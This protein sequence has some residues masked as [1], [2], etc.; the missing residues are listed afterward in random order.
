MFRRG[1]LHAYTWRVIIALNVVDILLIILG[2]IFAN[3]LFCHTVL[4]V[5]VYRV[6][7]V[8]AVLASFVI[9]PKF[10]IMAWRG[11]VLSSQLMHLTF[12][13]ILIF[14]TATFVGFFAVIP[15]D[16]SR[17]WL[18]A[19]GISSWVLLI[20]FQLLIFFIQR[21]F[22][23]HGW[24]PKK[25]ILLGGGEHGKNVY[26]QL[27]KTSGTGF[28]VAYI[29]DDESHSLSTPTDP[30]LHPPIIQP[31][32][33]DLAAFIRDQSIE[34]IW[35]TMPLK[36]ENK[37][38]QILL[39]LRNETVNV[40][41]VPDAFELRLLHHEIFDMGNLFIIN[42]SISPMFG[43]NRIIKF[44]EDYFLAI[45]LTIL[46]SPLLFIIAMLVKLTSN[47]PILFKQLRHGWNGQLFKVYK[48]RTMYV[49]QEPDGI[50]TQATR[51]DARITP[52][53]RFL[54]K[55]SLDE[56]PQLLNVLQGHMSMVGPRPHPIELNE[57]FKMQIAS[58]MQR[59]K[60][61][62]GITGWAQV[63]GWRG[64][65]DTLKKMEKRIEYDLYYI[66]NWS[67]YFDL[68][69]ILLTFIRG[70]ISESAY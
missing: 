21:S 54:R 15:L 8:I 1:L 36:E 33:S 52:L 16:I 51:N 14:S 5:R 41:F 68:K 7:I 9:L 19:W 46:L 48:F 32:P 18:L 64:E 29:L 62:P 63:N 27:Q 58:F 4:F 40:R 57:R 42:L 66:E 31:I 34:E 3:V 2:G 6:V 38:K 12:S 28:N 30:S 60:V 50:M 61:K 22:R 37:I 55:T 35:I 39:D 59:H 17:K 43:F 45:S 69:I 25:I 26:A 11:Q 49:H 47:G 44:L 67:L 24:N 20:L 53:G 13:W 10:R 56:L 65:T 23:H 70:I